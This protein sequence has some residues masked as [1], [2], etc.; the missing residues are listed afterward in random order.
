MTDETQVDVSAPIEGESVAIEAP[1]EAEYKPHPAHEKLLNELPEAWHQKVLPYLQE[2]DKYFQQ[3]IEKYGPYKEFVESG[4]SPDIIR[5][6]LNLAQAIE[7]Q[8]LDVYESL[9]AYLKQNG[10]LAEEAKQ[11]ARDIM[12]EESGEE[13][14]DLFDGENIPASLKREIEEL[15][16]FQAQ[17]QEYLYQ[18]ELERETQT[19][20]QKLE[21]GIN[22]LRSKYEISEA[23][24][25]AI[26]D[27]MNAAI[28]AGR[29][30][31]LE[32]AA[33]QLAAMIP[34]GFQPAGGRASSEPAPVV[35]GSA[36]G[37]GIQAQNLQVPKDD[38]AKRDMLA[39][40]FEQYKKS[41]Q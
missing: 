22:D 14:D 34:G 13:F 32:Q 25:I 8:P 15:K 33:Q 28:N 6:G 41:A 4:V 27:I 17:Q 35:I 36:G 3:E 30:I 12:E 7:T 16:N 26:Y 29:D 21:Q 40:M 18:Q 24:E 20:L 37:A 11:M 5:G 1:Q 19:E 38:D 10:I 9:T 2:Q 39:K 23:H 31:S